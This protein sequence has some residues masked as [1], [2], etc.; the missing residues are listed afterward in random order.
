MDFSHSTNFSDI[1]L[2][3]IFK[4]AVGPGVLQITC[5]KALNKKINADDNDD[6]I[7]SKHAILKC[8]MLRVQG[9]YV[10]GISFKM[11]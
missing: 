4:Q 3:N 9:N 6:D 11:D 7:V 2:R 8:A 5:C 10:Q 1:P